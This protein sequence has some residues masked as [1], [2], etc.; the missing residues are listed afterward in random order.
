M[1]L[2]C[3]T[4]CVFQC[5]KSLNDTKFGVPWGKENAK[6]GTTEVAYSN[7]HDILRLLICGIFPGREVAL[8][9]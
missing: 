5:K 6:K 2:E 1:I 4:S 7:F 3:P 8:L 9:K